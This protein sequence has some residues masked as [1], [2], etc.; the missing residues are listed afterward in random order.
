MKRWLS[1][2]ALAPSLAAHMVSMSTGEIRI[3]NRRAL[4]ELRMPLYETAH[5]KNPERALFDNLRFSSAGAQARLLSKSCRQERQA[6]V[7]FCSAT[8]EF[9]EPADRLEVECTFHSVTVPNH[10]HVLRAIKGDK[11]DQAIFDLTFP[12]ATIRFE[13]PTAWEIALTQ[14]GAGILRAVGGG[15]Q[16]LFLASLVLAARRRRELFSLAGMFLAGQIAACLLALRTGWEPAPRFVEAAAA[17][18]ISYLAVEILLLPKAGGR[19]LIAG[20][21]GTFHGLYFELF[22]R[23]SG[24]RP[25]YV[26]AG[27]VAAELA[28][29][30]VL[31]VLLSRIGKLARALRPVQA[32]A[33]LLLV[34]G[35]VWFF[36]RLKG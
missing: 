20:V 33:S 26:L 19:W 17:L 31:A 25:L 22:V 30:A 4:Y 27:V 16:I 12:K 15:A 23:S 6:G 10:V 18:T 21:L 11:T 34:I 32:S 29:I 1:I 8:Y 36:M 3:E 28:L 24:Y 13:P 9:P 7:F 5:A 35:I 2:L 14:T